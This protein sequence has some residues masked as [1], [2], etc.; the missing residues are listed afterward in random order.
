LA[1]LTW[2]LLFLS[3]KGIFIIIHEVLFLII[4]L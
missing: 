4:F 3:L 1:Y 2:G